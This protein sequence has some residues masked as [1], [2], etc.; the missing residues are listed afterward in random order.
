MIS[1]YYLTF[2]Y[3]FK[4]YNMKSAANYEQMPDV[5]RWED[6]RCCQMQQLKVKNQHLLILIKQNLKCVDA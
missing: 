6:A 1:I 5:A 4:F 3:T 2:I